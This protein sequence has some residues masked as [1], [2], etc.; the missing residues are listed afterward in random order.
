VHWVGPELQFGGA[1]WVW[2]LRDAV[3]LT[4]RPK[5]AAEVLAYYQQLADEV[6]AASDAGRLPAG[7]RHDSFLPAWSPH[8][9]TSLRRELPSY[10]RLFVMFEN[11]NARFPHSWGSAGELRLFRDL[12]HADLAPVDNAPEIAT[13]RTWAA[14]VWRIGALQDIGR[15]VRWLCVTATAAGLVAWLWTALRALWRRCAPDYLWWLASAALGGA[16]AV[17][18]ISL[19]VHITSWPDWRPL[20]FS[21]A[22]PLLL[23]FSATALA[24]TARTGGWQRGREKSVRFCKQAWHSMLAGA[25]RAPGIAP[26]RRWRH[27]D[28][29]EGWLCGL[30]IAA[31]AVKLWLAAGQPQY[32][33]PAAPYDDRLSLRLA[34]H[35]LEGHWLGPYD[36]LTLAKGPFYSLFMAGTSLL[37]L[38]LTTAHNLV[39][40]VAGWLFVRAL[41]PL[42]LPAWTRA[43]LLLAILACPVLSDTGAFVRAW[44]QPLWPGLVLLSLAGTIGLALREEARAWRQAAWAL[45]AGTAMGAMWLTREEAVWTL[46]MLAL[47]LLVAAWRGWR[48]RV[49]A[50]QIVF[51]AAPFAVAALAVGGVAAENWRVY[52]FWG[53]VEY[54]DDSFVAAY[55]ALGRVEP[56]DLARRVPITRAARERIYAVSPAFAELRYE[57]EEGI[58]AAFMKVTQDNVGIPATEHEIG[59]GWL[60]WALRDAVARNGHAKTAPEA[61]AFYR[62]LAAEVNTAC[63]SG[64][65]PALPRRHTML[66]P[67][68]PSFTARTW[69]AAG[70]AIHL[71]MDYPFNVEP[72]PSWGSP[73]DLAWVERITHERVAPS[74]PGKTAAL[75]SPR[76]L[77]ILQ[78]FVCGYRYAM[79][80]L[81]PAAALVWLFCTGLALY[82]RTASW[83]L[84][85][86]TALALGIMGNVAVVALVEATSWPA[87]HPGYLGASV[88]LAVCFVGVVF[89]E[90]VSMLPKVRAGR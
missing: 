34:T 56:H 24:A 44:R 71:I 69:T 65:L 1:V 67:W 74:D 19:L 63:D 35:L 84:V 39:Y 66:P 53:V 87:I 78:A 72:I 26:W 12:T 54:R 64:L 25:A 41:R 6:N 43:A 59:G 3:V 50:R 4:L 5:N 77:A 37:R 15:T 36:Q 76:R 79:R 29:V 32:A 42:R 80:W 10:L 9:A 46:P 17:F 8:Y 31:S 61:R 90:F 75:R 68:Q 81:L 86:S 60:M 7:P 89:I 22:Y 57:M 49:R 14:R 55:S 13:P 52:G 48:A 88:P 21:Q 18:T 62:R 30:L 2:A 73:E 45:L 23:L 16:L 70:E 27:D 20:R 51:L 33:I 28:P 85:L 47:P 83:L 40:I 11:F 58:G 38:P 82:R